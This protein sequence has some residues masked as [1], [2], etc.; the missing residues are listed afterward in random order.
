MQKHCNTQQFWVPES[1]WFTLNKIPRVMKLYIFLLCCSIG[2]AQAT[3]S[4]AQKA[5]VSLNMQNQTVQSVLDEIENQSEFSFF[6]NTRHVDLNRRVSVDTDKSDIFK[7]LDNI[8]AGTNVRYSVVDKKIILST[9][10]AVLQQTKKTVTGIVKDQNGEPVIGANVV[11]K[12]TTNGTV[13]DIDGKFMLEISENAILLIS[14]IGYE[15]QEIKPGSENTLDVKLKEDS[16][17]LD[18][19]VVVGYGTARRKDLAGSV[20]S[21]KMEDSPVALTTMT[22]GLEALR[23]TTP[24]VNVGVNNKAGNSPSM[25]IRGQ[26]SISGS[27]DP[28]I[29]LDGVV[30]LGNIND[31][32]PNDIASF[33][34]LK[35]ATSAA[36]YGSRSAN[37]VIMIN[38][39]KGRIGKPV[40]SFNASASFQNWQQKP[41]MLNPEQYI[42]KCNAAQGLAE[43]SDPL[44]WMTDPEKKNYNVGRITNWIDMVSDIG[45]QQDYQVAISGGAEKVNYYFSAA[46]TDQDGVVKGDNFHR[47]VILSKLNT[48]I[49]DWLEV[50]IDLGYTHRKYPDVAANIGEA[51][52][53]TPYGQP[54]RD[55]KET[56]LEKY[57]RYQGAI[58]PLWGTE[59]TRWNVDRSNSFR[60]NAH[61]LVKIPFIEGLSYR[62]NY[63]QIGD[64]VDNERFDYE[65]YFISEGDSPDRYSS[66]ALQ[67]L[68]S[69][70]NGSMTKKT[71]NSWVI[72][73]IINYKRAFGDDH[74]LDVTLV[75]TRDY[76]KE[77]SVG[78][79]GKDFFANGNTILGVKGLNKASVYEVNMG[80]TKKTNIGYLA[81]LQY[82]FADKYHLTASYRRD[83]ASVFGT[84]NK[85]GNF[86][87]LGVAWTL[88]NERFM[89][90]VDV[91]NYMKLKFSYGKNGNQGISPY[92]TLSQVINGSN[93]RIWYEFGNSP[94]V[95]YGMNINT[96]GNS[97]LGW[98][99]TTAL[100]G[101]FEVAILDNRIRL[102]MDGYVSK[103]TD[104]LFT[105][106][107]PI[108]TGFQSIKTSMGQ[109]N[110]WGIELNLKT[111]NIKTK[112]FEWESNFSFWLNRNKLVKL[113][114]DDLDGD[115]KEDDDLSNGLFIGKSLSAI[116]GY[117]DIG[118]VQED[119]IEYIK[120]NGAKP[121]DVK[122]QDLDGDEI[123]TAEDRMIL[124]Y[125]KE[126]FKMSLGNTFRYKQFE[127]YFLLNG[128]FGGNGYY[129]KSNT[130]A[131]L[132]ATSGSNL[133]NTLNHLWWTAENE[134]NI[135]PSAT[136]SDSKFKGLQ[137]R[138]FVRL[139][140]VTLSYRFDQS[141]LSKYGIN[142]LKVFLTGKNLFYLTGWDG[143]DPEIGQT[144]DGTFPVAANYSIG[145]NVS[146]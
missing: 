69:K 56:L 8:F 110:N 84:N 111:T 139:Q 60:G 55:E 107:I 114:G 59:G 52:K 28:L 71:R 77:E 109:V 133:N 31:I 43:D 76:Y 74:Y 14:Y 85:W 92:G 16:K 143:G 23:G 79:V 65:G 134:S 42:R 141:L 98:E 12:R 21:L 29:V 131:F 9:E 126:N 118:I 30:F 81:R 105:R 57:P 2:L 108:M 32:N 72:D 17:V 50:G 53:M 136:Y 5:T 54:Y 119:D 38:T 26:N 63:S 146:F 88:S 75:N 13:T 44:I 11:E 101:G 10:T 138:S 73:N 66:S 122:F 70:A 115:G 46:Y 127:L 7:V 36:A 91:I 135:Y 99:S 123:I 128:I 67:G 41:D 33:D 87:A 112:D 140:D 97:K 145:L 20:S 95:L 4:Y 68:L 94:E 132:T 121:G 130:S 86:P 103:T 47:Y 104:Q 49:T 93:S 83:G 27:N 19:V 18:E 89:S 62:F 1:L 40:I 117:K 120:N 51:Y 90:R 6:F 102:D 100:N 96:L 58:N 129:Q 48:H 78:S 34:I 3:N 82:T 25:S 24:G 35:D 142:S 45:F 39:K 144:I 137:S 106:N 125:E 116:Y 113:Y 15:V 64:F 80:A 22:S 124:G 61:V 37:G